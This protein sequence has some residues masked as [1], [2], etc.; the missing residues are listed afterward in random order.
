MSLAHWIAAAMLAMF[1]FAVNAQERNSSPDDPNAKVPALVYQ[2]AFRDYRPAKE[3]GGAP[4]QA[5]R[6]ANA[7]MQ[8]LGGHAGHLKNGADTMPGNRSASHAPQLGK[9]K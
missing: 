3:E 1:S 4:D 6:Q 2:S 9:E 5:W 8:A 7:Q